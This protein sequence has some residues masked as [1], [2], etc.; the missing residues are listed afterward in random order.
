MSTI[1]Y[2]NYV[3]ILHIVGLGLFNIVMVTRIYRILYFT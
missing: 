3:S 1:Y 2:W